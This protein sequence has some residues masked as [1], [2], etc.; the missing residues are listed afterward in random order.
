MV[1]QV[2]GE[3]RGKHDTDTI[4]TINPNLGAMGMRTQGSPSTAARTR[5]GG[6]VANL[7]FQ[8]PYY[9]ATTYGPNL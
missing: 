4:P 5:D 1:Q 2:L 3:S 7:N 8:Q 9:Q 6:A